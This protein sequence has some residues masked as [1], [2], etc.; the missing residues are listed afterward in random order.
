MDALME[1]EYSM[2]PSGIKKISKDRKIAKL[3]KIGDAICQELYKMT[4]SNTLKT[5]SGQHVIISNQKEVIKFSKKVSLAIGDQ[6]YGGTRSDQYALDPSALGARG[7]T[8]MMELGFKDVAEIVAGTEEMHED[9]KKQIIPIG[10]LLSQ[11]FHDLKAGIEIAMSL[12]LEIID[13]F[14]GNSDEMGE[15]DIGCWTFDALIS[16]RI[17][18]I[19]SI[20]RL[21]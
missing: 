11:V 6:K 2:K 7:N 21:Q 13:N 15:G 4:W 5:S 14:G 1:E 12:P 20:A 19:T 8:A 16:L 18:Q 9:A 3:F 10:R 17:S